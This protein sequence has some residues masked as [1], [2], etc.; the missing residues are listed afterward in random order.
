MILRKKI[1]V[2]VF[3]CSANMLPAQD[4]VSVSQIMAAEKM[5]DLEFTP[6]KRDSMISGV[7]DNLRLY[8]YMHQNNLSNSIPLPLWFD[9]VL[10]GKHFNKQQLPL[11][12]SIPDNVKLPDNK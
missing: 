4:S 8:H 6:A 12:W 2:L 3:L 10:P 1:F 11:Q 9:P 7:A 5:L